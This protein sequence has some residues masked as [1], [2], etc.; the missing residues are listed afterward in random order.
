MIATAWKPPLTMALV[1]A[2]SLGLM[3]SRIAGQDTPSGLRPKAILISLD[4][5][6]P[7]LIAQYL[8]DGVLDKRTGLGRLRKHGVSA[9]QNIT[10]TPALTAVSHIAVATGSTAVHNDIPSNTFHEVVRSID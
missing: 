10:A 5:A 6:R 8:R 2:S 3:Q 9:E 1:L 7:A 4:G